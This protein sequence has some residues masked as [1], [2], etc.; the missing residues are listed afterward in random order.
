M[1]REPHEQGAAARNPTA[2]GRTLQM[3]SDRSAA[4]KQGVPDRLQGGAHIVA[5]RYAGG[6]PCGNVLAAQVRERAGR[7]IRSASASDSE[8]ELSSRIATASKVAEQRV[9]NRERAV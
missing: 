4:T 7:V 6:V 9:C 8:L 5:R 3:V 2:C 1:A